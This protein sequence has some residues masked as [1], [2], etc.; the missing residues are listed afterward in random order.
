MS[1]CWPS[2]EPEGGPAQA[3]FSEA[4]ELLDPQFGPDLGHSLYNLGKIH[5]DKSD[6]T[7]LFYILSAF[8]SDE[9]ECCYK[10]WNQ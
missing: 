6:I 10:Y 7:K 2:L 9:Y 3:L 4:E 8:I 1:D 5:F